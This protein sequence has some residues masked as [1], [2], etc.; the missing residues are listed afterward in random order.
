MFVPLAV[1]MKHCH[2]EVTDFSQ[3]CTIAIDKFAYND[4][5]GTYTSMWNE[6][7]K[8]EELSDATHKALITA[9]ED[10]HNSLNRRQRLQ[11]KYRHDR[12]TP[13]NCEKC[14]HKMACV[15]IP[16]INRTFEARE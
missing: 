10:H 7:P 14:I 3:G 2:C 1:L 16:K 11:R 15:A 6:L 8:G 13:L 12:T 5:L 9:V 4:Y